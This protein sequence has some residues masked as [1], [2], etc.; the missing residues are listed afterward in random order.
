MIL[1]KNI[2]KIWDCGSIQLDNIPL[3]GLSEALKASQGVDEE[4]VEEEFGPYGNIQVTL[5]EIRQIDNTY[6]Y[7]SG[8]VDTNL[9][10]F[11]EEL[12]KFIGSAL[13]DMGVSPDLENW[14]EIDS[15]IFRDTVENLQVDFQM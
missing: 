10:I 14:Q 13:V 12:T 3:K 7:Y 9:E 8:M 6:G 11:F 1:S 5:N 15:D 4:E 2:Y